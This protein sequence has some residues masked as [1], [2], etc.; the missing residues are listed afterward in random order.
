MIN[1]SK[2][3]LHFEFFLDVNECDDGSHNCSS[4]GTCYNEI[5][6]YGCTCNEGFVGDGR[7]CS[8]T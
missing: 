6:A 4:D 3:F 2:I 1:Q 5:G 7:N 8:G